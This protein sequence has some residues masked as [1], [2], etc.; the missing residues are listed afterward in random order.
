MLKNLKEGKK[1]SRF[2]QGNI[3][4][5]CTLTHLHYK[6]MLGSD[7]RSTNKCGFTFM[8]SKWLHAS[9]RPL[10]SVSTVIQPYVCLCQVP[11]RRVQ[12][13]FKISCIVELHGSHRQKCALVHFQVMSLWRWRA[14]CQLRVNGELNKEMKDMLG[15]LH[16]AAFIP[17]YLSALHCASECMW[18]VPMW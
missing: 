16:P 15:C 18:R 3:P 1:K 17:L 6:L 13:K 9:L 4:P 11:E 2:L 14:A 12:E 8:D 7:S 5:P 10:V